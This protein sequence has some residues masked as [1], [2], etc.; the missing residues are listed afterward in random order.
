MNFGTLVLNPAANGL[1]VREQGSNYD[2]IIANERVWVFNDPEMF[3][4]WFIE[5]IEEGD[6]D[7]D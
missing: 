4:N 1:I 7:G 2:A 5:Y 6:E 3:F